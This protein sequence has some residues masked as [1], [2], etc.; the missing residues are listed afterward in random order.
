LFFEVCAGLFG[1]FACDAFLPGVL[2]FLEHLFNQEGDRAFAFCGFADFG[3]WGE[4]A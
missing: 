1:G 3:G 4:E 2:V